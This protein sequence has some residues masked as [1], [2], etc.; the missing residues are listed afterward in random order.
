MSLNMIIKLIQKK[1]SNGDYRFSDHAVRRM[2]K[3]S[4]DRLEISEAIMNCEMIEEYPED[5]YSP[6]CLLLGKTKTGRVLHIQ[7]SLPPSVVIITVY[8][9]DPK[10][11]IDF[12]K[13]R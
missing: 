12:R 2:I 6:S 8:E 11:W 4:I 3:R 7:L 9:P 13:R 1:I 5:K 10:E